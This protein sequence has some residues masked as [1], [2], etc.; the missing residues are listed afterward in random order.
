MAD[1]V[2]H[3]SAVLLAVLFGWAS[4]A[5]VAKPRAWVD[6]LSGYAFTNRVVRVLAVAVPIAEASVTALA[7]AGRTK[8][9]GAAAVGL[10]ASFSLAIVRARAVAGNKLPCGCFGGRRVTDFRLMLLR[11]ALLGALAAV[12]LLSPKVSPLSGWSAPHPDDIVP[13][14]L[15]L[16]GAALIAWVGRTALISL[17]AGRRS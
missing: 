7:L 10:L 11:N 4:L 9:A 6:A 2:A 14:A 8:I 17:G 13:A 3:T 15:V 1:P 12:V 5:K 16:L